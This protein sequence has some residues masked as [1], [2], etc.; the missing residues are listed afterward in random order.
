MG[1][2]MNAAGHAIAFMD[3]YTVPGYASSSR[4]ARFTPAGGWENALVL[5]ADTYQT[6]AALDAEGNATVVYTP[7][8]LGA[9]LLARRYIAAAPGSGWQ[10]SEDNVDSLTVG[11]SQD[12][13]I[14][15]GPDGRAMV[16]FSQVTTESAPYLR[17]P[18]AVR[19]D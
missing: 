4:V 6:R 10:P 16:V 17:L 13:Q 12:P 5:A 19:L 9:S 18:H 1:V 7:G 8:V 15:V 3:Y 2:A 14:A 11:S